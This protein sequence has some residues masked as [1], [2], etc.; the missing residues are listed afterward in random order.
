MASPLP[1]LTVI[2]AVGMTEGASP[3]GRLCDDAYRVRQR[4][5]KLP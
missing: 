3:P 4:V 2:S 5:G 1:T